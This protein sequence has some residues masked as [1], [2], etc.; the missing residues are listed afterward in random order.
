M[1]KIFIFCFLLISS[2][3]L[4]ATHMMGG[5][6]TWK[7]IKD[8]LDP[9][10]G[11]YIFTMKMY[12]D[13][14]GTTLPTSA[15]TIYV[16]DHPTVTQLSV[17]FII[18]TDISPI[19]NSINSG[20]A[21]L[22]CS[23]N[24]VGAVEEYIYIS[25]PVTLPG[26]PSATGWHF[27][28]DSCCRNGATSNLVLSSTISPGEGFT[29]RASMF[30]YFD[31]LTGL[32]IPADPCFDSSPI[33]NESPKTII[34]TGYPFAYSH[35]ASD[36]ELDAITYAWDEPL[37]DFIAPFNP[38]GGNP[39]SVPWLAPYTVNAPLPGNVNLDPVTGEISYNSNISG[40]FATV[41][42]VDAY[43]CAQKV[44]SIYREIQ[45]VLIACPTMSNGLVNNP[46]T[47]TAPVGTQLWT[48][49]LNPA[50]LPSY[51]TTVNAGAF[52]TF[53][54][55]GNDLDQ[56]AAGVMQD[57]TMEIS[58]GQ[59]AADYITTSACDNPPCATFTDLSGT[60]PPNS[61]SF[62]RFRSF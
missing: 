29:L 15:Q 18:S 54:I 30:P 40:N 53:D 14:D 26:L 11:K 23:S 21:C 4:H 33:F 52:I 34:C 57:I 25:Q 56:Y 48:T 51:S 28:W 42:R 55:V 49:T 16:W 2:V 38:A 59:M 20:N 9:N 12:R 19:G 27:T 41:V 62:C 43:K 37:D 60:P 31:P 1:K 17:N 13:C 6:I 58:G 35:N 7:C 22:D 47:I 50:G 10:V 3:P 45:A 5:E 39:P 36:E 32:Q 61:C 8:P 24:P 46:P 44:A